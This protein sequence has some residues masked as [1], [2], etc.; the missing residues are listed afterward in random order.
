MADFKSG[1]RKSSVMQRGPVNSMIAVSKAASDEEIGASAAYFAA[2]APRASIKLVETNLVPK[3]YVFGWH[4]AAV[5]TGEQEPIAGRIIE[6]PESLDDFESCDARATIIVYVP[7][8]SVEKG[9][10]LATGGGGNAVPCGNC[11]GVDL[12]G[13]GL[14]PGFAGRSPSYLVRQLYDFK[15]GARAGSKSEL[16]RSVVDK[17][18][19]DDM[20]A[21]AA[22]SA[23]L[24]P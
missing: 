18:S 21:I 23:S 19:I 16:M 2:A 4:L 13:L 15:S 22:Y 10:A 8:G 9:K 17:L 7:I 11:H 1:K 14:V 6:V 20:T 5:S 3:T 24:S 12:K